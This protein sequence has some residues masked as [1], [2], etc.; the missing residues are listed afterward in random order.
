MEG[1]TPRRPLLW[2]DD[3][4]ALRCYAVTSRVVHFRKET[5]MRID[6]K[7]IR[8]VHSPYDAKRFRWAIHPLPVIS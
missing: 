7:H 8:P 4:P 1:R 6:G 3:L 2:R 5:I